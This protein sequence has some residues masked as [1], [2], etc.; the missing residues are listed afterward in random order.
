MLVCGPLLSFRPT[1]L[2]NLVDVEWRQI[3]IHVSLVSFTGRS[4]GNF[5]EEAVAG[6]IQEHKLRN[7]FS[8]RGALNSVKTSRLF[9]NQLY[10][11]HKSHCETRP[12]LSEIL[13]QPH[14]VE[15]RGGRG[16]CSRESRP[17]PRMNIAWRLCVFSVNF[18][19]LSGLGKTDAC[20]CCHVCYSNLK[21]ISVEA[22]GR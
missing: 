16:C 5:P 14:W 11:S 8:R 17:Q 13:R 20:S 4:C 12:R 19:E 7:F 3:H 6:Q 10:Q 1:I 18:H 15:E 21:S 9:Q 22:G 2:G